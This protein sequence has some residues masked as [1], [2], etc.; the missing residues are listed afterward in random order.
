LFLNDPH[1][2]EMYEKD[3]KS[4]NELVVKRKILMCK[5]I[6][7]NLA[8]VLFTE[9]LG[10]ILMGANAVNGIVNIE[11]L[12]PRLLIHKVYT[13]N[14]IFLDL[15]VASQCIMKFPIQKY[16][17]SIFHTKLKAYSLISLFV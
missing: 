4:S 6:R 10:I 7:I 3:A 17:L 12:Q 2:V 16:I 5:K 14:L 8:F 15:L 1:E 11:L 9:I 13:R